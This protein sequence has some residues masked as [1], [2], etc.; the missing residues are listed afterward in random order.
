MRLSTVLV[1][2]VILAGPGLASA[3]VPAGQSPPGAGTGF[4]PAEV[5]ACRRYCDQL[6]DVSEQRRAEHERA[7]DDLEDKLEL[8]QKAG[9]LEYL[10]ILVDEREIRWHY[11]HGKAFKL[12]AVPAD[13]KVKRN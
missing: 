12:M 10:V 11:R 5:E 1:M 13:Y 8:Y 6:R 9:V 2:A 4:T 3:Q 7:Q